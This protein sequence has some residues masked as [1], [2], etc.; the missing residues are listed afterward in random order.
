MVGALLS[1]P[2]RPLMAEIY[3]TFSDKGFPPS[4]AVFN[5]IRFCGA[6]CSFDSL[7]TDY[8][9]PEG[10]STHRTTLSG[11]G[12]AGWGFD[13]GATTPQNLSRFTNGELRFWIH[14]PHGNIE[15]A[16]KKNDSTY[17]YQ[18]TLYGAGV[19]TADMANRWSLVR[20]PLTS[21]LPGTNLSSVQL[22]FIF[23][24]LSPATFYIDQVRYVDPPSSASS[25]I[26]SVKLC[27]LGDTA[28][29]SSPTEITWTGATT[30]SAWKIADQYFQIA[31]DANTTSWGVQI[32][33]DNK[34]SHATPKFEK[35]GVANPAGLV[36]TSD[37]SRTI[38]LAWSI[39]AG[40]RPV[41]EVTPVAADPNNESDDFSFQWLFMKDASTPDIPL[42]K[43]TAFVPGELPVTVRNQIGIHYGQRDTDIGSEN[44]PNFLFLEANF[45]QSVG[46]RSYK[47]STLTL[48][49]F[50]L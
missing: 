30:S 36:N 41:A 47:T 12:W 25:P 27:A 29:V 6:P 7:S 4:T 21:F 49:F 5:E 22:P 33:T 8:A 11:P 45:G 50:T 42:E 39:K 18:R 28:C 31:V 1:L 23:T 9:A 40:T 17:I 3:T 19:W 2:V 37:P 24:A 13:Y 10:T 35:E 26:Y 43:T 34:A 46:S 15:I 14:S 38:S 20:I 32:Y 48:E 44:P 16:I